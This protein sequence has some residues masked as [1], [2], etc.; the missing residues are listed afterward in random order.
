MRAVVDV[1]AVAADVENKSRI[2]WRR[3]KRL[4][5]RRWGAAGIRE[6]GEYVEPYE[7]VGG[8]E[9]GGNKGGDEALDDEDGG[10]EG[11]RTRSVPFGRRLRKRRRGNTDPAR[12]RRQRRR[13]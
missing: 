5:R 7:E 8:N 3:W 12:R 6:G 10:G 2:A 1:A 13:R 9:K 4:R 11:L